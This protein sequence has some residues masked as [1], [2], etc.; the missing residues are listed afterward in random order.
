MM[1]IDKPDDLECSYYEDYKVNKI[2]I[3][4]VPPGIIGLIAE[5]CSSDIEPIFPK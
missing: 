2:T 4:L 3:P 1:Q 5:P